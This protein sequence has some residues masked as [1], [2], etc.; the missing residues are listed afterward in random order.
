MRHSLGTFFSN[1]L[2]TKMVLNPFLGFIF[3]YHPSLEIHLRKVRS[4]RPRPVP[5]RLAN[6][7]IIQTLSDSAKLSPEQ[8]IPER[9]I[10]IAFF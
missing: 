4:G 7:P 8:A 1:S 2:S 10:G 5:P 3:G 9:P 6:Q